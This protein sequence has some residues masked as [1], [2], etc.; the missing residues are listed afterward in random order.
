MEQLGGLD[1]ADGMTGAAGGV[2][3]GL[4]EVALPH[5]DRA[6]ED[7]VLL[8]GEPVE[9]EE[10]ADAGPIVADGGLPGDGLG[11]DLLLEAGGGEPL[12]EAAAVA[13]VD[14]VL[15]QELEKLQRAELGLAG[16]GRAVGQRREQAAQAQALEATDQVRGDLHRS[17]LLW[18]L[19]GDG[20]SSAAG[21]R[22]APGAGRRC[23][24]RA[25]GRLV[26]EGGPDDRLHAADLDE[27]EGQGARAGGV[28]AGGA[29]AL[30]QPQELLGLAEAGPGEGAAEQHGHELAD[31]GTDLGR[32]AD[33]RVRAR[34]WRRASARRGSRCSRSTARRAAA[35]DGP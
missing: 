29:V 3:E 28:D 33:A 26:F 19:R 2:A 13:P 4:G 23:R 5:A 1:V 24:G 12:L 18:G 32:A 7:H 27:L 8:L 31:G 21:G 14:L 10:L 6:G 9:A 20:Q 35:A 30:G 25:R 15:E 11:R 22:S 34:A 16:M 17:L